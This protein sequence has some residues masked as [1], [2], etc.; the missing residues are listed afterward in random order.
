M[1]DANGDVGINT[2]APTMT[3]YVNGTSG[4][5]QAWVQSSDGRLKKNITQISDA[6]GI[7]ERLRGVRY[8]WR[9]ADERTIGTSLDLPAGQKEIGLIGQ[10]V[11]KVVPELVSSP[12]G[13]EGTYSL[14]EAN[15]VAVLVEAIKE[16]QAEV[17][18][19]QRKIADLER[20]R[21]ARQR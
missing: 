13:P 21:S 11:A 17:I 7:V 14:K 16:Q 18:Q 19:M 10:E 9:S 6:L 15:L 5:A 3:F 20:K 2:T 4:G 1:I 12:Q 8:E